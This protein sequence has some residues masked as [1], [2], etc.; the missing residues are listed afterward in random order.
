MQ[1][2]IEKNIP[3][4]ILPE[5]NAV[6]IMSGADHMLILTNSG[7]IFSVGSGEEGQL[8]YVARRSTNNGSLR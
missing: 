3:F 7:E 6:D 5:I 8:G 4:E 1:L 2:S